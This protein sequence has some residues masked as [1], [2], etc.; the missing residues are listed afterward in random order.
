MGKVRAMVIAKNVSKRYSNGKLALDDVSFVLERG[1]VVLLLGR[2]GAGKTSLIHIACQVTRATSGSIDLGIE[3]GSELGWCAQSQMIDWWLTVFENVYYGPRLAGF[4]RREAKARTRQAIDLV[5][6]T[7]QAKQNCNT[8]SGG[9]LQRVQV[10]RVLAAKPTVL[11]LDEPT[12]GLDALTVGS[13]MQEVRCRADEGAAVVVSSHELS[14]VESYC[15]DVLLLEG[16]RLVEFTPAAEFVA[17]WSSEE[18]VRVSFEGAL[19]EERSA[20]VRRLAT[21]LEAPESGDG[22]AITSPLN[23]LMPVGTSHLL[24][25]VLMG[26]VRVTQLRVDAPTLQ[27]AFLTFQREATIEVKA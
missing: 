8:L 16:G 17:S 15:D 7:G 24:L 23:A 13:L 1:R 19:T 9:Q 27:D 11:F 12:V 22:L 4:A 10:A 26:E 6:L 5:G 25:E 3:R 14:S 2:N 21:S 18:R 20:A